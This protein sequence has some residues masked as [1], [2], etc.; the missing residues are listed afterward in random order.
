M[1]ITGKSCEKSTVVL[2]RLKAAVPITLLVPYGLSE[3]EIELDECRSA[4][5]LSLS[6]GFQTE[7]QPS[8]RSVVSTPNLATPIAT[9][10]A[11][12]LGLPFASRWLGSLRNSE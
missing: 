7:F 4:S 10:A 12:G 2:P 9:S 8:E 1:L 3:P 6:L 5:S 11:P